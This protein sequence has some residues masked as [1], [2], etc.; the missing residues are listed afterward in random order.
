MKNKQWQLNRKGE[1]IRVEM[2]VIANKIDIVGFD[3]YHGGFQYELIIGEN[4]EKK[5][6]Q[7]SL[8]DY[9]QEK[10]LLFRFYYPGRVETAIAIVSMKY[11]GN[12]AGYKALPLV[13]FKRDILDLSEYPMKNYLVCAC[14]IFDQEYKIVYQFIDLRRCHIKSLR[15][16][17]PPDIYKVRLIKYP[18]ANFVVAIETSRNQ[19][20]ASILHL[21][22][23]GGIKRNTF[24]YHDD[25]VS[26]YYF[27]VNSKTSI[28][29]VQVTDQGSIIYG[30]NETRCDLVHKF[31]GFYTHKLMF[32]SNLLEIQGIKDG[33]TIPSKIKIDNTGKGVKCQSSCI[34]PSTVKT[35]LLTG[36][37]FDKKKVDL[38]L[39]FSTHLEDLSRKTSVLYFYGSY[40][41]PVSLLDHPWFNNEYNDIAVN[42][43]ILLMPGGAE[44]GP[45]WHQKG[46]SHKYVQQ[47]EWIKLAIEYINSIK[48]N[49]EKLILETNSAGAVAAISYYKEEGNVDGII[50]TSPFLHLSSVLSNQRPE[51][52]DKQDQYEWQDIND[53][54]SSL[55]LSNKC[56]DFAPILI[57]S[58]E[59]DVI[60][61]RK[62]IVEWVKLNQAANVKPID[63]VDI[64]SGGHGLSQYDSVSASN[65]K[66]RFLEGIFR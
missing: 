51:L 39:V 7:V 44:Y 52:L 30:I 53:D 62:K 45:K 46:V 35:K 41:R 37:T 15:M 42:C 16:K 20:V 61:P 5:Y 10:I 49:N 24:S 29:L 48:E 55:S 47:R 8:K 31:H 66:L 28:Y 33:S 64:A 11:Q 3:S 21:D 23:N 32:K 60:T 19:D 57:F 22:S 26:S 13:I 36:L 50:L 43:Y 34:F 6:H 9:P 1:Y 27:G 63:I 38:P 54:D 17:L 18:E 12:H 58:G 14:K 2:D 25:E 4:I 40:G 59:H 65:Q 56:S